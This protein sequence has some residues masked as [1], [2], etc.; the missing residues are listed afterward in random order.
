MRDMKVTTTFE[1]P[2]FPTRTL[3]T[4]VKNVE[5]PEDA[6]TYRAEIKRVVSECLITNSSF[7]CDDEESAGMIPAG[8]LNTALIS[9]VITL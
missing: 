6:L 5:S 2:G 9:I 8:L 7:Y 3:M 4:H 1:F